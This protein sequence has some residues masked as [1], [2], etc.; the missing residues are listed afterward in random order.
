MAGLLTALKTPARRIVID[1]PKEHDRLRTQLSQVISI[2]AKDK[3]LST[4]VAQ[5]AELGK[6][7][8]RINRAAL[9]ASGT[10]ERIPVTIQIT[11]QKL[12]AILDILTT[13]IR[14]D[15]HMRDGSFG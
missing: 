14:L 5:L 15:W 4:V 9:I 10:S 13:Q 12:S 6:I 1:E 7:D 11:N 8:L 2:D 3:T